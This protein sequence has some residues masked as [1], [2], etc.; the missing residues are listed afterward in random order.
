MKHLFYVHSGI[1]Y[2]VSLATI[3]RLALSKE[4]VVLMFA[5][6]FTQCSDYATLV[7][8]EHEDEVARLPSYGSGKVC[9]MWST[10]QA[11]DRKLN[12]VAPGGFKVYLPSDRNYLMQFIQ[13]HPLCRERN[14][15]EEGLLTYHDGMQKK[16]LDSETSFSSKIKHLFRAPF[17]RFRTN[18]SPWRNIVEPESVVYVATPAAVN[19]LSHRKTVLVDVR[20]VMKAVSGKKIT[21]LLVL[22]PVV[23][24]KQCDSG[25]YFKCLNEFV[26]SS[27][28]KNDIVHVKFHPR[29]SNVEVYHEIFKRHSVRYEMLEQGIILEELICAHPNLHVFGLNSSSLFYA[30]Q[31]GVRTTLFSRLL[32]E[33]DQIYRNYVINCFP[34][35]VIKSMQLI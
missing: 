5:R 17:H 16:K 23:E 14:F 10:L 31:W 4:D 3:K 33:Q 12:K 13:T 8:D 28:P 19:M 1:T 6:N 30:Q 35:G 11:L 32:S 27:L 25:T 26:L 29:Q 34:S 21:D 7:C 9:K 20:A 18:V 24:M 2:L 22:D 15:I